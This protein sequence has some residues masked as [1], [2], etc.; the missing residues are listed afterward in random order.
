VTSYWL[1]AEPDRRKTRASTC[2]LSNCT[3][4]PCPAADMLFLRRLKRAFNATFTPTNNAAASEANASRP[5]VNQESL[6]ATNS[7]SKH[8]PAATLR[9]SSKLRTLHHRHSNSPHRSYC[10]RL[11]RIFESRREKFVEEEEEPLWHKY[12]ERRAWDNRA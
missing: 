10:R 6:D 7:E 4:G 8:T 1:A 2:Q 3:L 12:D 9:F 5:E 11:A